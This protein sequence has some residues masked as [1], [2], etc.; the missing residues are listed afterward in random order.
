MSDDIIEAQYDLTNKS[1][2]KKFYDSYKTILITIGIFILLI[3]ISFNF[4]FYKKEQKQILLSDNYVKAKI[5]LEKDEKK[6]ALTL[7]KSI[8]YENDPTYST[9][10]L[11]LVLN[12]QLLN[13]H[14]EISVLFNHILENNKFEKEIKNLLIYKKALIESDFVSESELLESINPL[15][16]EQSFWKPHALLLV[17]DYFLSKKEYV[18]AKEFY[19]K[20]LIIKNLQKEYYDQ[21][22]FKLSMTDND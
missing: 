3:F 2:L 12:Q 1:K 7:L 13:D 22:R 14:K 11:F 15:L 18:K 9:L 19:T 5:F 17:G 16:N 4:Y 6:Q 20:I 21:A 8:I 10:S